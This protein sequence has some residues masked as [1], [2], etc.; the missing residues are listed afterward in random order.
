MLRPLTL[1]ALM[2]RPLMLFVYSKIMRYDDIVAHE[3]TCPKVLKSW[4]CPLCNKAL[5]FPCESANDK[6]IRHLLSHNVSLPPHA[7]STINLHFPLDYEDNRLA[8]MVKDIVDGDKVLRE[9]KARAPQIC[10]EARG[11]RYILTQGNKSVLVTMFLDQRD[12][13]ISMPH[14]QISQF[15]ALPPNP[16]MVLR[17]NRMFH[18]C[19]VR[20]EFS[21]KQLDDYSN[22]A[23]GL[24]ESHTLIVDEDWTQAELNLQS[25]M[26]G[27]SEINQGL[28]TVK[29]K[30]YIEKID[31]DKS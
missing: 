16:T 19:R 23:G 11:Q 7:A 4:T 2:L 10:R 21:M 14:L 13:Q 12:S 1:A 20:I 18:N 29:F 15:I 27:I 30:V 24:S 22:H 31:G 26:Q 8:C 3:K 9:V 6:A 28:Y 17:V 5:Q 25:F